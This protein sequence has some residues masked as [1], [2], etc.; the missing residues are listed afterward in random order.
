[1]WIIFLWGKVGK[2]QFFFVTLQRNLIV[3]ST[4]IG[5][6]EGKCD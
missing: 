2:Y 6:I 3:M 1:M 4:F 5:H